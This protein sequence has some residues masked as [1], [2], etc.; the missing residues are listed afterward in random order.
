[1]EGLQREARSGDPLEDLFDRLVDCLD[2][3][4]RVAPLLAVAEQHA[5]HHFRDGHAIDAVVRDYSRLRECI[6]SE[7][8]DAAARTRIDHA[9]DLAIATGVTQF[10]AQRERLR[11]RFMGVLAH[12]LRTPLACVTMATEMLLSD[13]RTPQD[14]SLLELVGDA[15]DRMQRMVN[16]VLSW[17]RGTIGGGIPAVRRD[18]DLDAVLRSVIAE[19]RVTFGETSVV[20]HAAGD[21]RG[22][23]DR[24]RV[25]QAIGNLVRNAIEHGAGTAYVSA[26]E[27][28]D[29]RTILLRVRNQGGLRSPNS[30]DVTDP[31][32]RR[33]RPSHARGLGLYIVDQIVRAHGA[34][35]EMASTFEE[36]TITI[37]WP[38]GRAR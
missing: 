24:D 32:Q 26:T 35:L 8:T 4:D 9:I 23:F 14:R 16:E 33:K 11:E 7:V 28:D 15:S 6:A 34:A 20:Y 31:F 5:D 17:A 21:L 25:H 1:M 2:G 10:L 37:R 36:T 3:S 12:D 38:T 29:G 30:S 13:T 22:A 27:S 18:C 19:A